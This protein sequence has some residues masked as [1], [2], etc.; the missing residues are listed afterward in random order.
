[1]ST[2]PSSRLRAGGALGALAERRR[3][4]VS[5]RMDADAGYHVG[6]SISRRAIDLPTVVAGHTRI[7]ENW[8]DRAA[9]D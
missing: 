1:M 9:I 5:E 6:C 4:R 3:G 8:G 2:P 7:E